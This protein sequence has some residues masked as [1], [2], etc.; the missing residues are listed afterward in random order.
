MGEFYQAFKEE[1][2]PILLKLFQ[3][4]EEEE[5]LTHSFYIASTTLCLANKTRQ[6]QHVYTHTNYRPM[7]LMNTDAKFQNISQPNS[8]S[9]IH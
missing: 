6:R 4:I 3:K 8:N 9:I 5:I 2:M 7:S 1:L